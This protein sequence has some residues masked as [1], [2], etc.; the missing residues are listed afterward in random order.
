GPAAV[1]PEDPVVVDLADGG[2]E[3][4]EQGSSGQHEGR[5]EHRAR[6]AVRQVELEA[7]AAIH[8]PV[9][10][11]ED[12]VAFGGRA[13]ED[14]LEGN[15]HGGGEAHVLEHV[16]GADAS[17]HDLEA[18]DLDAVDARMKGAVRVTE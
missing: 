8:G 5:I 16:T 3:V 7:R 4:G 10:R 12:R 15:A 1:V 13:G 18:A 6:D 14:A 9:G 11:V 2:R 17:V